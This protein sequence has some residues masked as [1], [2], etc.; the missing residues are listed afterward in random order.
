MDD[1]LLGHVGGSELPSLP[2]DDLYENKIDLTVK[3]APAPTPATVLPN[4]PDIPDTSAP[5][6]QTKS[7]DVPM[8]AAEV[9]P[10]VIQSQPEAVR[11]N[12]SGRKS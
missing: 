6:E 12:I 3:K 9:G 4:L 8:P 1:D 2:P 11:R 7:V 5:V 10:S